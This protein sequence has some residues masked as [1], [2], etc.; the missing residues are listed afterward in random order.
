MIS[1]FATLNASIYS[2]FCWAAI[3]YPFGMAISIVSFTLSMI[4]RII[5]EENRGILLF[6]FTAIYIL[7]KKNS[8]LETV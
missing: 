8:S 3:F 1:F 4:Y 6:M 7:K 2:G 5:Y